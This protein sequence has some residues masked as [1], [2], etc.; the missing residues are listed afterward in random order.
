MAGDRIKIMRNEVE[1]TGRKLQRINTS[2]VPWEVLISASCLN[3][4]RTGHRTVPP[5]S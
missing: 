3:L 1:G 5:I 2:P 4:L